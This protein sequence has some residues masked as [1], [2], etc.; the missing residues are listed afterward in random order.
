M[1]TQINMLMQY[2]SAYK[3]GTKTI[4]D[5]YQNLLFSPLENN[6]HIFGSPCNM[7]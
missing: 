5:I 2:I 6:I 7:L 3:N 4:I 1:I